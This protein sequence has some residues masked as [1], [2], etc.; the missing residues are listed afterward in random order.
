MKEIHERILAAAGILESSRLRGVLLACI[1]AAQV[2]V[3]LFWA[4]ERSN[5]YIDELFSFG[6]AHSY[7]L[8]KKEQAYINNLDEWT[9]EQWVDNRVL[10]EKLTVTE[11]ESLL[12]QKPF[13][14]AFL[15]VKGRNYHGILNL[16]MSVFAPGRVTP[17]PAE[18]LNIVL[19]LLSQLVL[20]RIMKGLTGSFSVSALAVLMYGFSAMAISTVLYVRFYMLVTFLLLA[21]LRIHQKMWEEESLLRCGLLTFIG[22]I[23]LYFALKDSELVF[24]IGGAL[25]GTYALGLIAGKQV[26]KAIL[27]SISV[28]PAGLLFALLKTN[29]IDIILHPAKYAGGDGAEGWMTEKLLTVSSGRIISLTAKYLEWLSDLLFGSWYVM[30][31]FIFLILIL[32]EVRILGKKRWVPGKSDARTSPARRTSPFILV[33]A[34]V[35]LIYYI[36]AVLVTIPAERYFMFYYPML[37]ILLWTLLHELTRDLKYRK[38]LLLLC[39]FLTCAGAASLQFFRPEKID[40]VYR[41]DRP[42]IQAVADSGVRDVIVINTGERHAN[43]SEYECLNLLPAEARLYPVKESRHSIN[44]ADCPDEVLVWIRYGLSP[45]LFIPDLPANGYELTPLGR[46]HASDIY[47][48]RKR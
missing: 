26:K 44:M 38:E 13:N 16:L 31:C 35:C 3:I 37:A 14:A 34:A 15:L 25:M 11:R 9:Y 17:W 6:S 24:I 4:G 21:L 36:F 5:Y 20:F 47:I 45:E 46:T 41:G 2:L 28:F 30:C 27:Y 42:A 19:F 10:K 48:A 29:F 40:F 32:L 18:V 33:I 8:E 1:L 23:L 43:H 22:M 12:S 7:T 39:F